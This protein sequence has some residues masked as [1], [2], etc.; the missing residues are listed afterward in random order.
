[1][2]DRELIAKLE[3]YL[4][5]NADRGLTPAQVEE[6]L[7]MLRESIVPATGPTWPYPVE[8]WKPANP[9][10]WEP[11]ITSKPTTTREWEA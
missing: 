5:A 6:A 3:G 7:K 8:P 2:T 10:W 9:W 4:A 11:V 1:M